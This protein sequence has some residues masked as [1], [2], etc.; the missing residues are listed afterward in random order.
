MISA[1]NI[2]PEFELE[3]IG[4]ERYALGDRLTLGIFFKTSC[5]TCQ[6]AWPFYERLYQAYKGAGLDV[7]GISQHDLERTRQFAA[8]YRASFPHLID[9]GFKVSLRYN[10]E[11]VPTG[12]LISEKREVL[13]MF[14]S[15]SRADLERVSRAIATR[16]HV[17]PE[18]IISANE[19]VIPFKPG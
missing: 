17:L 3:S 9:E 8:N 14:V 2:A 10:P 1:G 15:W 6:Y 11:F 18:E 4:G 19:E 13:D 12:F 5:P 7:W 16:L